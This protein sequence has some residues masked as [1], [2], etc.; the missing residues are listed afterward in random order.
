[1]YAKLENNKLIYAPKNL[2]VGDKLIL[3]FNK[4]VE[5]MKQQGY[6][7]IVDI[8]P[9]YDSA[10]YYLTVSGYIEDEYSITVNYKLNEIIN[11]NEP[12]LEER[13]KELENKMIDYQ[14]LVQ[15]L[16]QVRE[17]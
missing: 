14:N 1:M 12:T 2:K 15:E 5:L 9:S 4:N 11:N 7:E 13:I 16:M 8:K 17:G 6:K 10:T 3:N